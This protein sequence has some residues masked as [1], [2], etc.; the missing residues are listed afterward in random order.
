MISINNLSYLIGDRPLYEKASLHIKPQDRIG[1]I[2]LNGK[3]KST[4]LRLIIGDYQATEGD[5]SKSKDC[6][7]GF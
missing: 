3:G 6:T 5:I 7:I 2:G 4:L 1:L